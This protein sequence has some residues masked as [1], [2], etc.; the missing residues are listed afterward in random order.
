MPL[1]KM[2]YLV[3]DFLVIEQLPQ[4]TYY[5]V[6]ENYQE[7]HTQDTSEMAKLVKGVRSYFWPQNG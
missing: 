5:K 6:M 7:C 4:S 2:Q 1:R 3:V